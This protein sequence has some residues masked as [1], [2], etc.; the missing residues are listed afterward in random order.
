MS[1]QVDGI[2]RD[3]WSNFRRASRPAGPPVDREA[4]IDGEVR[5]LVPTEPDMGSVHVFRADNGKFVTVLDTWADRA[6]IG[7]RQ[8][9]GYIVWNRDE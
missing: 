2:K 9:E 1:E 6:L 7:E 3:M 8:R 4:W 5:R